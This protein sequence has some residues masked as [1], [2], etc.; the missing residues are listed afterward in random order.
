MNMKIDPD[1]LDEV[2]QPSTLKGLVVSFCV[3]V[4][5]LVKMFTGEAAFEM[6]ELGLYF[7]DF[8]LAFYGVYQIIR[9]EDDRTGK[10]VR[11]TN[12]GG[13]M[14]LKLL[15]TIFMIGLIGVFATSVMA[16]TTV[17][18]QWM[19]NNP[20]DGVTEYRLYRSGTSGNYGSLPTAVF[21]ASTACP[22]NEICT[23]GEINVPDGTWYWVLTA[24]DGNFESEYSNEVTET[25]DSIAPEPPQDLNVIDKIIAWF[26]KF[27]RWA[28]A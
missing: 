25:L 27:F 24:F 5:F 9:D 26:K 14:K 3:L 18:F 22:Q 11:K 15:L 13:F 20:N 2:M 8:A 7:V 10:I 28:W 21:E 6:N 23:G 1:Q 12:K 16:A 19:A 4:S 17:Q